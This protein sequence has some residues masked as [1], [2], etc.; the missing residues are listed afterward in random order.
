MPSNISGR[1]NTTIYL[2]TISGSLPLNFITNNSSS[3][4][5]NL[6]GLNSY[7]G[8]GKVMKINS[9]NDGLEW[10]SDSDNI[11]TVV[12]PLTISNNAISLSNLT[13][14]GTVGQFLKV[15]ANNTLVYGADTN[16]FTKTSSNISP[17]QNADNLLIGTGT[18]TNTRKVVIKGTAAQP[19]GTPAIGALEI[20]DSSIF[21][22]TG[23][24][25]IVNSANIAV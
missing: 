20:V 8:A 2:N 4:T 17:I 3:S 11:Y 14:F 24:G 21:F 18:N 19:D 5:I 22:T 23:G 12:S 15:G 9:S 13:G 10:G 6:G 25:M 1:S 16:Y 7:G